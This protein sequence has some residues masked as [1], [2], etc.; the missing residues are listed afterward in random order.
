MAPSNGELCCFLKIYAHNPS[1][2]LAGSSATEYGQSG[3]S[4][5]REA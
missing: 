4:V 1:W 2:Q 5:G 3:I